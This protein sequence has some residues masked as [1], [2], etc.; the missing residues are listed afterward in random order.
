MQAHAC[1]SLIRLALGVK[2]EPSCASGGRN[3]LQPIGFPAA[4]DLPPSSTDDGEPVAA[5]EARF[6]ELNR[7]KN[8]SV[9]AVGGRRGSAGSSARHRPAI[10][11][12]AYA[13]AAT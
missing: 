5:L 2:K 8:V 9:R 10:S 12:A 4:E 7:P 11:A 6:V 3:R 13:C 1:D